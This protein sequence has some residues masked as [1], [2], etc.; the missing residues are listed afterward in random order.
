V[1]EAP[2]TD[3]TPTY[4]VIPTP[5]TEKSEPRWGIAIL[6]GVIALITAVLGYLFGS[7]LETQKQ[8]MQIQ[9]SAYADF[10]KGQAAWQ[11]AGM[12]QKPRMLSS[13]SSAPP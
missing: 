9:L 1:T 6:T 11:R 2:P 4:A 10:A 3:T 8:H 5:R 7:S 13:K 12:I